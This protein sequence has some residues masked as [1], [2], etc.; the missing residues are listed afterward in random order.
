[1]WVLSAYAHQTITLLTNWYKNHNDNLYAALP[2]N[3]NGEFIFNKN[4]FKI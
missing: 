4:G 2:F 3:K 1:M